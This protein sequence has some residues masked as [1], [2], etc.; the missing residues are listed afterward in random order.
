M[1]KTYYSSRNH[2][3][4]GQAPCVKK[5]LLMLLVMIVTGVG[6]VWGQTIA[7]GL[8]Y[9]GSV[10]YDISTPTTNY[11]LCPTEGW[12]SY[13]A[14]DDF[15]GGDNGQPFLTTYQCRNGNYDARKYLWAIEKA[16]AP[17]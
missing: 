2:N 7:D 16:P 15:E 4:R 14:T 12:C 17:N 3:T 11:Y 5:L 1:E 6:D 9:I 13:K 8:Y 10:G